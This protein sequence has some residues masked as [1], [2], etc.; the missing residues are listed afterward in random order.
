MSSRFFPRGLWVSG[1]RWGY[2]VNGGSA[3]ETTGKGWVFGLEQVSRECHSW[4][5]ET[6][7]SSV[8]RGQGQNYGWLKL[9]RQ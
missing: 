3:Q 1:T 5:K 7:H 9:L 4:A 8:H 2:S 6:L